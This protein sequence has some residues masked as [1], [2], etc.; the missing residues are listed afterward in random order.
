MKTST[1]NLIIASAAV[2]FSTAVFA[3]AATSNANQVKANTPAV[4]KVV[5]QAKRMTADE[6][7]AYDM[8][9]AQSQVMQ[10]IEIRAKRLTPAQKAQIAAE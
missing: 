4:Q 9:L 8:A 2:C 6:K 7:L 1:L 10:V 5:V 3:G